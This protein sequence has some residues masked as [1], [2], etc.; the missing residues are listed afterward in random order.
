MTGMWTD[1]EEGSP[2]HRPNDCADCI[3]QPILPARLA[4]WDKELMHFIRHP[5]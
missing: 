2:T 3:G 5:I 4:E 1:T